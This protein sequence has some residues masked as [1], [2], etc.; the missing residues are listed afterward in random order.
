MKRLLLAVLASLTL[1][2]LAGLGAA[3]AS[4]VNPVYGFLTN[5]QIDA[6]NVVNYGQIITGTTDPFDTS[7]TVNFTNYGIIE[8]SVGFRFDTAPAGSGVRRM[9]AN[10]VNLNA[11]LIE[12]VDPSAA[13]LIAPCTVGRVDPSY[14]FVW[15]T[16][17]ICQGGL[18]S[19][20]SL[21]VGANGLLQL[22]G[23]NID[24]S[25]AGVEVLGVWAEALGDTQN[26]TT[27]FTPD[28]GVYDKE[29]FQGNFGP[30]PNT[31][32]SAAL[33]N[34]TTASSQ[35]LANA[36]TAFSLVSPVSDSYTN[37]VG[38]LARIV[39]TN[40]TGPITNVTGTNFTTNSFATNIIKQ[41]IFAAG[42]P[43]SI[44]Q[45]GFSN[46]TRKALGALF[47]VGLSNSVVTA[48][49]PAYIWVQDTLAS[50]ANRGLSTNLVGCPVSTN[51]ARPNNYRMNRL[52]TSPGTPGGAGPPPP[53]AGL[54]HQRGGCNRHQH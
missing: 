10:F 12:A 3:I 15:A 33:W 14:L 38:G 20:E 49:E 50:S 19:G 24:L 46:G 42:T 35:P 9:M 16:N 18:S 54:F 29:A 40:F 53:P 17:I 47:T 5:P 8:G 36:G 22:T 52:S 21:V 13:Q 6:T 2:P 30:N 25:R 26:G 43:D 37:R 1:V 51:N 11:G 48:A 4:Y 44:V 31:L 23:E 45:V 41:A 34:G 7:D 32:D 28:I 39:L 27:N